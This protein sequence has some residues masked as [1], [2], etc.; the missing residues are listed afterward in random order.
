MKF[1]PYV[2][3]HKRKVGINFRGNPHMFGLSIVVGNP[4][5]MEQIL[6][7]NELPFQV[8][9]AGPDVELRS[10]TNEIKEFNILIMKTY[11]EEYIQG[12]CL[13]MGK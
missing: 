1:I 10:T 5:S 4:Q 9:Y 12:N 3:Y 8:R 7:E 2:P 11:V 6:K 13:Q